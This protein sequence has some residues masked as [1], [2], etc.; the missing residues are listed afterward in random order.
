M[1]AGAHPFYERAGL[2]VSEGRVPGLVGLEL[3][4][5]P[6][7]PHPLAVPAWELPLELNRVLTLL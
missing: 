2:R 4:L 6:V 5:V 7:K 3:V 1:G